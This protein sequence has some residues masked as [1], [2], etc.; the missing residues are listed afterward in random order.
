K[1]TAELQQI[2]QERAQLARTQQ[3]TRHWQQVIEH[4]ETF[5]RL[6]GTNLDRLSFEER[7]AVAHCLIRKVVVTAEQ[8]DIS[9]VLP[10]EGSPQVVDRPGSMPEGTPGHFY[11][12]RL[13]PLDLPALAVQLSELGDT[14][15]RRIEE[16]GDQGDLAGPEARPADAI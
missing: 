10:F 11:R 1:L 8:V 4:A 9:Y 14:G 2:E 3:R 15:E 5:R 16:R 12:L 7:Q 13:A 6:L